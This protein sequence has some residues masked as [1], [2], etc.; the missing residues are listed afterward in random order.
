[1]RTA[2]A[3][4][5][6]ARGIIAGTALLFALAASALPGDA[7]QP[8]AMNG[9]L[10]GMRFVGNFGPADGALDRKDELTFGDGQFWSAICVP[11]GFL[12]TTYW[13]RHVGDAV[14]FR[15]EMGSVDRGSFH[16]EG[17][18][19]GEQLSATVQW[20]KERWYWSID[21][22]FRFEGRM[23]EAASAESAAAVTQR[24]RRAAVEPEQGAVC[25]L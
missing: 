1:M 25:P 16:Y 21:R 14:H 12:P 18:I 24:A 7:A 19:R 6:R 2:P 3:R 15:G 9:P 23:S 8:V 11:C 4:L 10:D 22:A 20:R 17:V 5:G 13:I